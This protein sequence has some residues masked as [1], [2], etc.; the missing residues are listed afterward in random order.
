MRVVIDEAHRPVLLLEQGSIPAAREQMPLIEAVAGDEWWEDVTVPMLEV[1]LRWATVD[2]T[3]E[4][5][6]PRF[7]KLL[8]LVGRLGVSTG[9]ADARRPPAILGLLAACYV[10]TGTAMP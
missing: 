4:V 7:S 3:R 8:A 9:D 6:L 1:A 2:R 5:R 10:I